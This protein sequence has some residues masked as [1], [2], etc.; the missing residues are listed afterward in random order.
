MTTIRLN[1][2]QKGKI[3]FEG[4]MNICQNQSTAEQF[5]LLEGELVIR[6]SVANKKRS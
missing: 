3:A 4:R 5:K 6:E 1:P 2:S